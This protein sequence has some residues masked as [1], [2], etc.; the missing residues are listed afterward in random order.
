MN[1]GGIARREALCPGFV[2]QGLEMISALTGRV[3][4]FMKDLHGGPQ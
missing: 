4:N 3:L 2:D 1:G